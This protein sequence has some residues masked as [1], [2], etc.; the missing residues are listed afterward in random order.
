MMKKQLIET[1]VVDHAS[2]GASG[3]M[4]G[5]DF[6]DLTTVPQVASAIVLSDGNHTAVLN[7]TA[8]GPLVVFDVS[9]FV[10]EGGSSISGYVSVAY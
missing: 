1:A 10:D 2:G 9:A 6:D 7:V 4:P 5:F 8:T 3:R